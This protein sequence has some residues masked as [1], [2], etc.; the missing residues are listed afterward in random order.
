MTDTPNGRSRHRREPSLQE[1]LRAVLHRAQSPSRMIELY[2]WS[3]EEKLCEMIRAIVAM[4]PQTREL[5][6]AFLSMTAADT[7]TASLD[8]AGRLTLASQEVSETLD[9]LGVDRVS[10]GSWRAH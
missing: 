8:G 9:R 3:Q 4:Q 7:V 6:E 10:S 5:L 1:V 2:Y